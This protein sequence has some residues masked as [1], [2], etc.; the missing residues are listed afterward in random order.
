VNVGDAV[1]DIFDLPGKGTASRLL[2]HDGVLQSAGFSYLTGG[3]VGSADR[4][5]YVAAPA[6][7]VIITIS[8][9]G[10]LRIKCR[11][12]DDNMSLEHFTSALV[13]T[14]LNLKGLVGA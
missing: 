4:V 3:G 8:F 2:Y 7:G 5:D 10:Y 12:Q 1:T 9:Y 13:R 11:F 6:D 14:G